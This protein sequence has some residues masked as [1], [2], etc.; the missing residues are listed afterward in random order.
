MI[1]SPPQGR[2]LHHVAAT[3]CDIS[4][5]RAAGSLNEGYVRFCR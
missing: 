5:A 2:F 3:F 4:F 1:F